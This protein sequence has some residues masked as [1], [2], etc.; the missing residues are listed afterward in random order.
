MINLSLDDIA[1]HVNTWRD[2]LVKINGSSVL[3]TIENEVWAIAR[4]SEEIPHIG[5]IYMEVIARQLTYAIEDKYPSIETNYY[6]NCLD[7]HFYLNGDRL[8]DISDFT[9]IIEAIA[10][11]SDS[12]EMDED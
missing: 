2:V 1:T 6:I 7:S 11:T 10:D 3:D 5:N 12:G 9:D 4:E 8:T